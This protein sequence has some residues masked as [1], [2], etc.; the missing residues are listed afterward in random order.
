MLTDKQYKALR[1]LREN[2]GL[3]YILPPEYGEAATKTQPFNTLENIGIL[4]KAIAKARKTT[5]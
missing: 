1:V 5:R 2:P 3:Q 4:Q